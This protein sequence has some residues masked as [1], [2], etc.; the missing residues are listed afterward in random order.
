V[1]FPEGLLSLKVFEARYLDLVSTCLREGGNFGVVALV[2]G[3]EVQRTGEGVAFEAVGC[4]AE[5][6]DVD[7][8]QAGVLQVR[9][10]GLQRFRAFDM[11]QSDN[12]LWTAEAQDVEPDSALAPAAEQVNATRGLANAIGALARR[13]T[14]PFLEPFRFDDAGW[15]ANRWCELLPISL[16]ARQRLMELEDPLVRLRLVD[17]YLRSKGLLPG[18]GPA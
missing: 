10:R 17:D 2:E 11:R 6:I 15:V 12:G 1:L 4:R 13:G 8:E 18:P 5:L 3:A 9:C 16:K 7:A 14:H